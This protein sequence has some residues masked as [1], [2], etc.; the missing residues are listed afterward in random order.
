MKLALDAGH[1]KETPGK[2][3]PDGIREWFLNNRVLVAFENEIT[4]YGVETIRTDDPT[5][6]KETT[7]TQ[8]TNKAKNAK[9]DM[10][11]SFHH[12]AYQS[13]WG[14]HGGSEAWIYKG[15]KSEKLAETLLASIVKSLGLRNRGVKYGNMHVTRE[16]P[17]PSV[18]LE[19]GFMDSNTDYPVITNDAK[20]KEVGK[21]MAIAFAKA[22]NLK[23]VV[24]PK[25]TLPTKPN[26]KTYTFTIPKGATLYDANGK[27]YPAKTTQA[28]KVTII[29]E[30]GNLGNFKATWLK[31]VNNAWVTVKKDKPKFKEYKHTIPSGS[32]LY[33]A[34]GSPYSAKTTNPH[35]VTILEE[36][37]SLG[38]FK[39]NWLKGVNEAWID[40]KKTDVG[41][42]ALL[43]GRVNLYRTSTIK[44]PYKYPNTRNKD[45]KILA[46][47]SDRYKVSDP[48]FNPNEVWVNKKDVKVK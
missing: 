15:R 44:D 48:A 30:K 31:G 29:N 37:G 2:R 22:Y 21:N 20:A 13:K 39:A 43:R 1:Y 8:R 7:L 3:T 35:T 26:F 47:T 17:F 9:A 6:N 16:V 38:R 5:G 34:Q 28:H 32:K 27:A 18:L 4:K 25:P 40:I 11:I 19:I 42:I 41:K 10:L 12:N 23:E 33:N 36:K 14:D 46:E 45:L 24:K